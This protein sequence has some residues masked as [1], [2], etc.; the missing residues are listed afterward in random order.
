MPLLM[1]LRLF[2]A[3]RTRHRRDLRLHS[4][5]SLR[6]PDP[7][8]GE[9]VFPIGI[10]ESAERVDPRD[11]ANE[12]RAIWARYWVNDLLV[13]EH[14][15]TWVMLE[16]ADEDLPVTKVPRSPQRLALQRSQFYDAIV[17]KRVTL[18]TI[19]FSHAMPRTSR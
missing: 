13:S 17:E 16:L 14:D 19:R 9:L 18:E 3:A 10:W 1:P 6:L 15:W 8:L 11:V 7:D 2:V 12:L 5:R 4:R